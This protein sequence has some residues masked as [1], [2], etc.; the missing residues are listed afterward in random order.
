MT[1]VHT[2][3]DITRSSSRPA[4]GTSPNAVDSTKCLREITTSSH[5]LHAAASMRGTVNRKLQQLTRQ[6]A[7]IVLAQLVCT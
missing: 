1:Y 7:P 2:T 4:S 6:A 3:T 5:T